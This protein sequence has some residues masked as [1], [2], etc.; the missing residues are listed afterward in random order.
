LKKRLFIALGAT[1][2]YKE[3][4]PYLKKL[5]T[6][7]GQK[8][9]GVQWVPEDNWHI[10][11]VFLGDS[12]AEVIPKLNENIQKACEDF[13][14]FKLNVSDFGGFPD[15]HQARVV[16][17][18]VQRSQ[19]LLDLQSKIE[20]GIAE[21]GFKPEDRDYRPHLTV[22]R[23]RN[24]KNITDAISPVVRKNIGDLYVTE[25]RLYESTL[26][27]PYPRY[28]VIEKFTLFERENT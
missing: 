9:I 23:L 10:T 5:K 15:D 3:A 4:L 13:K 16:Y 26:S 22:G 11:L 12:Q 7:F 20:A 17:L 19:A 27:Q 14:S 21:L 6:N 24:K 1:D 25:V 28:E 18:A 2:I 8:E